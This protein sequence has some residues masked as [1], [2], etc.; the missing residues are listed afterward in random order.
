[1]LSRFGWARDEVHGALLRDPVATMLS[2]MNEVVTQFDVQVHRTRDLGAV[3]M[4]LRKI[5][6]RH[7]L[8]EFA[9]IERL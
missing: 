3:T 4:L 2:D 5:L 8:A 6:K 7:E 9:I 1:M